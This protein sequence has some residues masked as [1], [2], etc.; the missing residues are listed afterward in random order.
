MF[1]AILIFLV[2]FVLS[3]LVAVGI[4]YVLH[5]VLP[6]NLDSA[7][8]ASTV[9]AYTAISL[10]IKLMGLFNSLQEEQENEV[11]IPIK[12]IGRF[13]QPYV[14]KKRKNP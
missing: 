3:S 11:I 13:A 12:G 14:R 2:L 9:L 4:G 10:T 5:W 1:F 8:I 7:I 6:I